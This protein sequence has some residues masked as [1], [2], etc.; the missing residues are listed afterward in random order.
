LV[1]DGEAGGVDADGGAS[2]VGREESGVGAEDGV[3]TA[4]DEG[5]A[6]AAA[7][8][9]GGAAGATAVC[10]TTARAGGSSDSVSIPIAEVATHRSST[11]TPT[12]PTTRD[13]KERDIK[14]Y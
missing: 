6:G 7:G 4:A 8:A 14:T 11:T 2:G 5:A 12:K 3:L 10:G 1:D 13:A 9:A